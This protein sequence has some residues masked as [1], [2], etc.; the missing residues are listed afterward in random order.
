MRPGHISSISC[1]S[2][3]P[4]SAAAVFASRADMPIRI[5]PVTSFKSAQRP[6]SS[7]SSSQRVSCC[8][9]SVL[10]RARSVVTTSVR[11]GGGVLLWKLDIR[12]GDS[13][14]LPLAGEVGS[15]GSALALLGDPGG[16]S[17]SGTADAACALGLVGGRG[18][19]S[20]SGTADAACPHPD[21]PPHAG[22]GADCV[23]SEAFGHISA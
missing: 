8:G 23:R 11:L 5:A 17:V 22:E 21:P 14:P 18:G 19:A 16:G 12:G 15:P 20:V 10:P 6:V 9:S 1:G 4:I 3:P 13:S 7:S 2:L